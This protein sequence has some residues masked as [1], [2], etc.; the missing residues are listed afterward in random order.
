MQPHIASG[1]AEN[2]V[3][4][5]STLRAAELLDV[6]ARVLASVIGV[7]EATVS[8][9]RK[10]DFLLERGTKPFELAVLFVRLFR[11][12][13]AIVGGDEGIARAWL[14]NANTAFDG[15]PIEK[16]QTISGLVDVI[17]YL[18]SRRALV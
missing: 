15:A 6:T 11:S 14:K 4:T 10:Q 18:D 5:K 8:R 17:A 16:I 12:L 2:A 1:T 9:M 13:D 7:S 3:V